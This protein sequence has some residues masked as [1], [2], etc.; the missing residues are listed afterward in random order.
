M[1][2]ALILGIVAIILGLIVLIWPKILNYAVAAWLLVWGIF[3]IL[4]YF[5]IV[6]GI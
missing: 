5:N 4:I 2:T 3:E 1:V 6:A